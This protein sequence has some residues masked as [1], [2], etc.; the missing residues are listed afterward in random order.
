M[1][2]EAAASGPL[3]RFDRTNRRLLETLER[4]DG[5]CSPEGMASLLKRNYQRLLAMLQS[6]KPPS[7][8]SLQALESG[9]VKYGGKTYPVDKNQQDFVKKISRLLNLDEVQSLLLFRNYLRDEVKGQTFDYSSTALQEIA[10]YYNDE[11]LCLLRCVSS[12]L[13]NGHDEDHL[14]FVEASEIVERLLHD[15]LVDKVLQQYKSLA[16]ATIPKHLT[17]RQDQ[18][19]WAN[20]NVEEQLACLEI[21]FLVYY[22]QTPISAS[23]IKHLCK[24]FN[25]QAFGTKQPNYTL[26]NEVGRGTVVRMSYI[27]VLIL[28]ESF[29]LESLLEEADQESL[30]AH[31]IVANKSAI[32]ELDE[33]F[34]RWGTTVPQGPVLLAWAS[35]VCRVSQFSDM[36]DNV[37]YQQ[38]GVKALRLSAF[39]FLKNMVQ[40]G[41]DPEEPNLTGYKSVLKGLVTA[42]FT[43]FDIS[44]FP[45]YELIVEFYCELFQTE[46]GLCRQYW[47]HDHQHAPR[48]ALMTIAISCWPIQFNQLLKLLS[49][50]A[51][52]HDCAHR[53]FWELCHMTNFSTFAAMVP[54]SFCRDPNDDGG[55]R[56]AT[57]NWRSAEEAFATMLEAAHL[58]AYLQRD[59]PLNVGQLCSSVGGDESE[60]NARGM[61]SAVGQRLTANAYA[62]SSVPMFIIPAG[63]RGRIFKVDNS[64]LIQWE[65]K[66]SIWEYL[67]K[68][69]DFFLKRLLGGSKVTEQQISSVYHILKLINQLLSFDKNFTTIIQNHLLEIFPNILAVR[70]VPISDYA[71]TSEILPRLFLIL[72]HASFLINPPAELLTACL[73]CINGFAHTHPMQVWVYMRRVGL[74]DEIASE[75]TTKA[76]SG[77]IRHLLHTMECPTG[78][79]PVTLS[80]LDLLSTLLSFAQRWQLRSSS[81]LSSSSTT[82]ISA[83]DFHPCLSYVMTDLFTAFDTW[84]YTHIYERWQIGIKILKIFQDI[85]RDVS[86]VPSPTNINVSSQQQKRTRFSSS[87]LNV[88]NSGDVI[89]SLKRSLLNSIL[90]DSSF[91]KVLLNIVG[92]GTKFLERLIARRKVKEGKTLEKLLVKAFN[93]LELVLLNRENEVE[94]QLSRRDNTDSASTPFSAQSSLEYSLLSRTAVLAANEN[95]ST[96]VS[97]ISAT[98]SDTQTNG[99]GLPTRPSGGGRLKEEAHLIRIIASYIHY[100]YNHNL[101]LLATR[102]LTLLCRITLH[103]HP[104]PPSLVGYLGSHAL[105]L[106]T[107][108]LSRL[109]DPLESEELRIAILRLVT[110]ALDCQPGLALLFINITSRKKKNSVTENNQSSIIYEI[111]SN[112]CLSTVLSLIA[113]RD[114]TIHTETRLFC[115]A[116]DLLH[117]LWQVAPD[118]HTIIKALRDTEGFWKQLVNTLQIVS[119]EVQSFDQNENEKGNEK[120][121]GQENGEVAMIEKESKREQTNLQRTY[122]TIIGSSVFSILA[123]E[124]YY[125][126]INGTLDP[127]LVQEVK[128]LNSSPKLQL[129][130]WLRSIP[131]MNAYTPSLYTRLRKQEL[132]LLHSITMVMMS[133]THSQHL[134]PQHLLHQEQEQMSPTALAGY[135]Q[136]GRK[137]KVWQQQSG[138]TATITTTNNVGNE[139]RLLLLKEGRKEPG[140][141]YYYDVE[142]MAKKLFHLVH[143]TEVG[144]EDTIEEEEATMEFDDEARMTLMEMTEERLSS[145]LRKFL[146]MTRRVNLSLSLVDAQLQ[147]LVAWKSFLE[148]SVL[149]Q[150]ALSVFMNASVSKGK[151]ESSVVLS[152]ILGLTQVLANEEREDKILNLKMEEIA[153]LLLLLLRKHFQFAQA[154]GAE[155]AK[156]NGG[157][158]FPTKRFVDTLRTAMQL[159]SQATISLWISLLSCLLVTAKHTPLSE[160]PEVAQTLIILLP[161]LGRCLER[162]LLRNLVLSLFAILFKYSNGTTYDNIETT[163]NALHSNFQSNAIFG[164]LLDLLQQS[165]SASSFT[166]SISTPSSTSAASSTLCLLPLLNQRLD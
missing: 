121:K 83:A 154:L 162:P 93:V 94:E 66:Y 25:K 33:E 92:I 96:L 144:D 16:K 39:Q 57:T 161:Q 120:E 30:A 46:P 32:L 137:R 36:V 152:L 24:L 103:S 146:L 53:V 76:F 19:R 22:A 43:A 100:P 86:I 60:R 106:R 98:E 8:E 55:M 165:F 34:Q 21:I 141:N 164:Y 159:R 151:E 123:L 105:F 135:Q 27:C 18:E 68:V 89:V 37:P 108:F 119:L 142:L 3:G 9:K 129:E 155:K 107:A 153:S 50:L 133:S 157:W 20:Q 54:P 77:C 117:S 81:S 47:E 65:H 136:Q 149:R 148:V 132:K 61:D 15:G 45:N 64:L 31:P 104:R 70:N 5:S 90:Y 6:Y 14:Y 35:L 118:H 150:P 69:L 73:R 62:S 147:Y 145:T 124:M 17:E 95:D 2:G 80:F 58:E 126:P 125:V 115:E 111:G 131:T 158:T 122:M 138:S 49:A 26:L 23:M 84:R 67:L 114:Q 78:R 85:L 1:A 110:T 59:L 139:N 128:Q 75:R 28:V 42:I 29:N 7:K 12:L 91:H 38:H 116:M 52:D 156:G 11:R 4:A 79:Y 109:K 74:L 102:L 160:W 41:F 97:Q 101:P 112:S 140:P 13:R 88:I 143:Q 48:R 63:T 130:C 163:S 44:L 99:F 82:M 10:D 87:Q 71:N 134:S 56:L 51:G 127:S 40:N 113:N 166:S 72:Q